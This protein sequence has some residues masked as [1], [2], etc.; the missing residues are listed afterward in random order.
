MG[1]GRISTS[2]LLNQGINN[3]NAN[4]S[5]LSK[6]QE[7][8]STNK[9]INRP[10]DDP[11][12]FSRLLSVT[13]ALN[14]DKRYS[15]NIT[16]ANS[17]LNTTDSSL[18]SVTD[19]IARA[20]ELAVQG[21]NVSTNQQGRNAIALEIDQLIN[22]AVQVANTKVGDKFIFAGFNNATAPFTRAVD[23][24]TYSG[25]AN[26]AGSFERQIEISDGVTQTINV[27]GDAVFG[28]VSVTSAGD[29]PTFAAGSTGLLKT[30]VNLKLNLQAGNLPEIRLRLDNLDT[31]L[32]NVDAQKA[33]VGSIQNRLDLAQNRLDQRKNTFTKEYSSIQDLD[34]PKTISDL[35]FQQ[36]VYQSSLQVLS[37]V[38]Q[39]SLLSFLN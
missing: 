6:L 25:S 20:K 10:S 18:T 39:P 15:D 16:Q 26:V 5:L 27:N 9:N 19:I 36:N 35:N 38:I 17:E 37:R 32:T 33:T 3:L 23:D 14:Y 4:S 21:A 1:V 7:K 28:H 13:D 12:G 8:L 2:F 22:Q 34:L 11:L 31:D 29:P 30:L 24:V